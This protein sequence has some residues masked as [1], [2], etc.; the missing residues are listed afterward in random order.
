MAPDWILDYDWERYNH[1]TLSDEE[2]ERLE[3]AF[4]AFFRTRTM[5]EL[6]EQAVERR[7]LLASCNDAR[8]IVEHRQLRDRSLFTTL[9][10]PELGASI[11]HPAFFA[12]A[13]DAI[14][15]RGRAPRLGE[16][17]AEIETLLAGS[18]R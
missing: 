15:L 3:E 6:Y 4:G 1:N 9:D 11:E 17:D 8:E 10:Y 13:G 14:R 16:H 7:I 2:I 18:G 5:R 12:R